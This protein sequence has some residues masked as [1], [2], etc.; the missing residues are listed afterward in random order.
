[1]VATS[2]LQSALARQSVLLLLLAYDRLIEDSKKVGC[3]CQQCVTHT[4]D[5]AFVTK[6]LVSVYR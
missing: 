5:G 4:A 1:M 2:I 6:G 3:L